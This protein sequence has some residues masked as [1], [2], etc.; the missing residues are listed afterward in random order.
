MKNFTTLFCL[1][2]MFVFATAVNA[3]TTDVTFSVN[4]S[5]K[6]C[7]GVF[8]AGAGDIAV[9]RGSFNDWGGNAQ[10]LADNGSEIY[11]G[12]FPMPD[13]LAGITQ[14]FKYVLV[15]AGSGDVWE[16]DPNREF[17]FTAGTPISVGSDFFDR[18]SE[19]SVF[20][21]ED[22]SFSVDM[23]VQICE[24]LF[25]P[26]AGDI[27]V[28]RGA[29]NDWGGNAQQLT[30]N[31]S[32]VY[33]AT[34]ALEGTPGATVFYKYVMVQ[35]AGDFWEGDP[36]REYVHPDVAGS[37][38]SIPTVFFNR[39]DVC[40]TL[41]TGPV[42]FTI[43]M[44]VMN[45]M[46]LFTPDVANDEIRTYGAF[47]GWGPGN[48]ANSHMQPALFG[49]PF[50]YEL[51]ATVGPA[52]VG[53]TQNY[54]FFMLVDTVAHGNVD[55]WEEPPSQ[56]GGN[57][58]FVFN[59][60]A[61]TTADHAYYMDIPPAGVLTGTVTVTFSVDMRP[62]TDG[63]VFPDPFDPASDSVFFSSEDQIQGYFQGWDPQRGIGDF[64]YEDV[65]GDTIYEMTMDVGSPGYAA[66]VYRVAYGDNRVA[67]IYEGG[68]FDFGKSRTRYLWSGG[69]IPSSITF[70]T[71]VFTKDPPLVVEPWPFGATSIDD[72]AVFPA[73]FSLEQNYPNPFNP[74]TTIRFSIS[75]A[76][77]VNLVIYNALGQKVRT[78][79]NGTVAP[80]AHDQV[81][82]GMNESGVAV[83]SGIYFYK[84]NVDNKQSA[85]RKMVLMR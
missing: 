48:P 17:T 13:S 71:D 59:G 73:A 85:V 63:N 76:A 70:E 43:D 22:I 50:D 16:G 1:M 38:L 77:D 47:N 68:G 9:V 7:E 52:E 32:E 28:T 54:K 41:D 37:G 39:D 21:T 2:A 33:E 14:A 12:V 64:F 27:V 40:T 49:G 56:G 81:W 30:D 36:N 42:L 29:F 10:Q 72:N 53:S 60:A 62:A 25:D 19:C 75:R 67:A 51:N 44:S 15:T 35:A 24:N 83:T 58:Q 65:D 4:L 84:L 55:G 82:D 34:F 74:E 6:I 18:D 26:G 3:Q 5:V 66:M 79:L 23:S 78:L 45:S 69:A 31:G 11:E 80:G 8:D 61:G 57:R 46:G 20:S